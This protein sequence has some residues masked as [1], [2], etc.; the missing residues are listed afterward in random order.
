L[1]E[2]DLTL[3]I[4]GLELRMS[5][6]LVVFGG[7]LGLA[8][9]AACS[10]P[11]SGHGAA[12]EASQTASP[13]ALRP[14]DVA[15]LPLTNGVARGAITTHGAGEQYVV[16]I[17]STKFD[18]SG[19]ELAWSVD[20]N[21]APLG[22]AS[23]TGAK[24][25]EGCSLA[26]DAWSSVALPAEPA[27]KGAAVSLGATKT[28]RA[29][30]GH[31]FEDIQVKA[32]A[33]GEHAVVWA[34]VTAAHPAA[35]DA[36]FVTQFL[37]DFEHTILPRERTVFGVES[38]VDGDGRLGLVFTPLTHQTAV[39][40][41]TSCDVASS[42]DCSGTNAGDYLWLTPPNAIDP[43]YNTP[44]AIKEIL[45][46]ELSHLIHFNRKVVRNRLSD[47]TDSGYMIEGV[48]GFAQ[49]AIGPQAGNLYV[50]MAGLTGIADFSLG[51]T[52]VDGARYDT[53]RDGALRGGS[54]LFV[55][56]LYDR[57]GGDAALPS[58]AIEGRG[59]PA[60]L[61]ALLDSPESIAMTLP[62]VAKTSIADLGTDFYTTLA[63]SNREG[64]GGSAP[65]NPC[66]A[67][68]PIQ[69]DPITGKQRGAD[70]FARF[71][72]MQMGGVAMTNQTSGKVRA[73]GAAYV[74][75]GPRANG[76]PL[77]LTVDVDPRAAARVR[78]ARLR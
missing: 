19:N 26:P 29:S 22:A 14:G 78:I 24:L 71:H 46:H 54:Y 7:V 61:R 32:I 51:D 28:L 59:G 38:D 74:T 60:L 33:V 37:S 34:D 23:G 65:T 67:Y 18:T 73:G 53:T 55:R 49:D 39:A 52:L 43:P 9:A 75:M 6:G 56:W 57:A 12:N 25:V 47:W 77:S 50:A 66:F 48:G 20:A 13:P 21:A 15:E 70:L 69:T 72:G 3:G 63:M 31:G 68:R 17:A 41:F 2:A 11:S 27:P 8:V 30:T 42:A 35:L 16:I 5:R 40:F 64:A 36:A 58:G 44:N 45:T 62:R 4:P 76:A 1:H 10:T